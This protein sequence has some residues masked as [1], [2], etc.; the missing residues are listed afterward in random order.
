M[1]FLEGLSTL[2]GIFIVAALVLVFIVLIEWPP[3]DP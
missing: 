1:S 2:D 3:H